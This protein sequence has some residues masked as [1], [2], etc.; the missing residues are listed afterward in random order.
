MSNHLSEDQFATC[1]LGRET[2]Q[3]LQHMLHCPACREDLERFRSTVAS[4]RSAVRDRVEN[5]IASQVRVTRLPLR[6]AIT[7]VPKWAWALFAAAALVVTMVPSLTNK[8]EP[9]K[10]PDVLMRAVNLH[11]SRTMPAAMEPVL[12]LLPEDSSTPESGGVQ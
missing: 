10:D 1:L 9:E 5:Q 12:A 11:L 8:T 7:I 4:F 3:E 2:N 6:P